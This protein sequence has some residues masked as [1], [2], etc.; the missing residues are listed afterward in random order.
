MPTTAR[1]QHHLEGGASYYYPGEDF[2]LWRAQFK[3]L[4][5]QQQW[6]DSVAKPFAFLYMRELAAEA[7]MNIP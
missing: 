5:E 6:S 2:D 7:V 3:A 4:C 1:F